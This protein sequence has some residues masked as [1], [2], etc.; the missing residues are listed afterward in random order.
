MTNQ[1]D[2]N[3]GKRPVS[4]VR[5]RRGTMYDRIA[6]ARAKRERI[7]SGASA[8]APAEHGEGPNPILNEDVN[9]ESPDGSDAMPKL[10]AT[11]PSPEEAGSTLIV[12]TDSAD[13]AEL[14]DDASGD[15]E[16]D[17]REERSGRG[18]GLWIVSLT[19]A[20]FAVGSVVWLSKPAS[21]TVEVADP[22]VAPLTQHPPLVTSAVAVL[23]D[24]SSSASA[25]VEASSAISEPPRV[26]A[27]SAL[28][29]PIAIDRA[30]PV[31]GVAPILVA[32]DGP[33]GPRP[34]PRPERADLVS[35]IDVESEPEP[36]PV[37]SS[38]D[39]RVVLNAPRT[40]PDASLA[41]VINALAESGADPDP[42]RVNLTISTSNVRYYHPEDADAATAIAQGIGAQLRDFTDFEPS[43]PEGLVEIW[44]AGREIENSGNTTNNAF[45]QLA[46]DLIELQENLT[47]AL[48]GN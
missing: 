19:I 44:M 38:R 43:P 32:V 48:R 29:T 36:A 8:E 11:V 47:R 13:E 3:R 35:V 18:G 24:F 42:R 6:E 30:L 28:Q 37:A 31:Y 45:S 12:G 16:L 41:A 21:K 22:V 15:L 4:R 46:Q 2:K 9:T 17:L 20:A 7:L 10:E 14:R 23:G 27:P 34:Q 5:E 1:M 33:Q 26:S 40:V 25:D 39:L